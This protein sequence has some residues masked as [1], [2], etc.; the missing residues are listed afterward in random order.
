VISR[1]NE[2]TSRGILEAQSSAARD[3]REALKAEDK[4]NVDVQDANAVA[5]DAEAVANELEVDFNLLEDQYQ[6]TEDEYNATSSKAAEIE[7][8]MSLIKRNKSKRGHRVKLDVLNKKEQQLADELRKIQALGERTAQDFNSAVA[9]HN[10]AR[11]VEMRKLEHRHGT[12]ASS[13]AHKELVIATAKARTDFEAE[14]LPVSRPQ[15]RAETRRV[16]DA[17]AADKAITR[18]MAAVTAAGSSARAA[19]SVMPEREKIKKLREVARDLGITHRKQATK[20]QILA[21]IGK[22]DPT[23]AREMSGLALDI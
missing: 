6:R 4:A 22:K 9:K 20:V 2:D 23:I 1:T 21:E 8:T 16:Q 12:R 15:T 14:P 3:L 11:E 7:A 13:E 5:E 17:Q 10:I 18:A 19:T